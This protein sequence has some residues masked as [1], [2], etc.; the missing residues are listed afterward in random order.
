MV[1]AL[2][3]ALLKGFFLLFVVYITYTIIFGLKPKTT[4]P[5]PGRGGLFGVGLLVGGFSGLAGVGGAMI[6]MPF[7]MS[8]GLAFQTAIGTGSAISFVVAIAG[9]TG[10]IAA[11][12][13]EPALR[14]G[15]SATSTAGVP[16]HLRDERLSPRLSGRKWRRRPW[17]LKK[18]FALFILALAAKLFASL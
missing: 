10:F 17:D 8:W 4:R 5:V 14:H 11:G 15:R 13:G 12:L 6:S 1:A 18:F 3:T 2:P 16:G 9:V 7:M